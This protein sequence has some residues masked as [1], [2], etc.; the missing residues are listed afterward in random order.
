VS[1]SWPP[2]K[3]GRSRL[4][5]RGL[6]RFAA[7]DVS[8]VFV[9]AIVALYAVTAVLGAV[10]YFHFGIGIKPALENARQWQY[11]GCST[12]RS[13]SQPSVGPYWQLAGCA[14]ATQRVFPRHSLASFATL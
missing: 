14:G 10:I 5:V 9:D 7:D 4:L 1:R 6:R 11:S 8:A 12:L 13:I 3:N 2:H